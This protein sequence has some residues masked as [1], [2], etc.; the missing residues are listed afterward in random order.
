MAAAIR[1]DMKDPSCATIQTTANDIQVT[2][3]GC[4]ALRG[5]LALD[6]S[7]HAAMSSGGKG[8]LD[9]TADTA[10]LFA[11]SVQISGTWQIDASVSGSATW[12][13]DL[14]VVGASGSVQAHV[15]ADIKLSGLCLELSLDAAADAQ[16]S[17][18][19]V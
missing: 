3:H 14:S 7:F 1:A 18:G 13:G 9:V 15:S 17:V 12:S 6:G 4:V 11:A 8:S 19:G 10:G 5:N 16:G 2:F